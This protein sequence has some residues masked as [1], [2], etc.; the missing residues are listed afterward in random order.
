MLKV[1]CINSENTKNLI[2]DK[3]YKVRRFNYLKIVLFDDSSTYSTKRFEPI[4]FDYKD[5][6]YKY[7]DKR[8]NFNFSKNDYYICH[9]D[10]K[11]NKN[12]IKKGQVFTFVSKVKY[13]FKLKSE[14]GYFIQISYDKIR[15]NLWVLDENEYIALLRKRKL[16]KIIKYGK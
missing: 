11:Y 9:R 5:Y 13:R 4:N 6:N 15:R 14:S 10:F 3:E 16:T 1:K 7:I 2:Q 12:T 8:I